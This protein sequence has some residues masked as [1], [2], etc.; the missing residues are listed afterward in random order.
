MGAEQENVTETERD[1]V[2]AKTDSAP[3]SAK[4]G[5]DDL[6]YMSDTRAA[7]LLQTPR[8]GRIILWMLV[9]FMAAALGWAYWAKLDEITSGIGKVIPSRQIQVVQNLEGGILSSLLMREGDQV[10]EGQILLHIDDTRFSSSL[11]ETRQQ[12]LALKAKAARLLAEATGSDFIPPLEV[13]EEQPSLIRQE[14]ALFNSGKSELNANQDILKEQGEQFK[15]EIAE[16]RSKQS[17]LKRSLKLI[18][19]ELRMTRPLVAA[20][21][22]SEVEVLRLERQVND[23]DGELKA[24]SLAIPK[25]KS[26]LNEVAKKINELEI[27]FRR[28]AR[29]E[30]NDVNAELFQLE[31]TSVALADRVSRTAVRSPVKGTVKQLLVNTIGGVIQPGMELVEIVP[32]ED[33]LL[34]EAKVRPKDIAFLHPGQHTTVK[35]TAYDYAIF[36]GLDGVLEHISA[37]T[38]QEEGEDESFYLV[39]VRTEK[40]YLGEEAAPLPIISGMQAEVDIMT[41]KKTVLEYLLKPVLRAKG[42][43]LTER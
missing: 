2:T 31:E 40:T 35:I 26:K 19:K 6:A 13:E 37:D 17:H 7:I 32:L 24:A 1:A 16:L 9:L 41:G 23:L 18:K 10:E 4:P 34:I 36:G 8:G 15:Q 28:E 20:G 5:S 42:R 25:S 29:V 33:S 14:M 22:T 21:A 43:A 27:R 3:Q 38:I 11:R 30:L 39:R 12:Y